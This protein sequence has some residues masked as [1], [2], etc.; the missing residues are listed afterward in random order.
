M[1]VERAEMRGA[2]L[3]S[4][5]VTVIAVAAATLPPAAGVRKVTSA[6]VPM[7]LQRVRSSFAA[8]IVE[9]GYVYI[10]GKGWRLGLRMRLPTAA[11]GSIDSQLNGITMSYLLI[12]RSV[13]RERVG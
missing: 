1:Y 7:Q 3:D 6:K 13:Q 9:S 8:R 12:Q 10:V 2:V 4:C 5:H 11:A